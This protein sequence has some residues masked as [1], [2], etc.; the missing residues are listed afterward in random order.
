MM[1]SRRCI[2]IVQ[3]GL[4]AAAL[5]FA[6][7]QPWLIDRS[8]KTQTLVAYRNLAFTAQRYVVHALEAAERKEWPEENSF[9][10]ETCLRTLDA[11]K[12]EDVS[13]ARFSEGFTDLWHMTKWSERLV[14]TRSEDATRIR[15]IRD[16]AKVSLVELDAYLKTTIGVTFDSRGF[17]ILSG[18]PYWSAICQLFS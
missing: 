1:I 18:S 6:I 3:T 4:T 13:P 11:V 10:F 9:N 15:D 5:A 12:L 14:T 7:L 2:L 8:T 16:R 17:A